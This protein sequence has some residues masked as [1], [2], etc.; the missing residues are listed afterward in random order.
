MDLALVGVAA[1]IRLNKGVCEEARIALGAVAPTPMRATEAEACLV[2]KELVEERA[3]EAGEIASKEAQPISDIRASKEYR[4]EMIKV[5]T[6]RAVMKASG[7]IKC[8]K[9]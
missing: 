8:R 9:A 5:L 2:G 4:T 6:K 1:S 7:R 3:M